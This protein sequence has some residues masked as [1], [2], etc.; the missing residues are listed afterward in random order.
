MKT[1]LSVPVAILGCIL[2]S[3]CALEEAFEPSPDNTRYHFLGEA[4]A[5]T[6]TDPEGPSILITSSNITDVLNRQH[7]VTMAGQ[8][9]L[10]YSLDN[11]WGERLR[12]G[13]ERRVREELARNLNTNRV[14]SLGKTSAFEADVTLGYFIDSLIGSLGDSVILKASWWL[15]YGDERHFESSQ[16]SQS[17]QG[18][19]YSAYVAAVQLLIQ[20]WVKVMSD[21][22]SKI[23]P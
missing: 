23:D 5:P 16:F 13:L 22:I 7:I 3:G 15:E 20:D 17:I 4:N 19:D 9:E 6:G 2:A 11:V 1:F 18:S 10:S 21:K 8:N 14:E 12:D